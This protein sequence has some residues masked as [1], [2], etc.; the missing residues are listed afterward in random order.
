MSE[1]NLSNRIV[2]AH[3]GS[4]LDQ[5]IRQQIRRLRREVRRLR[6]ECEILKKV[7]A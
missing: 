5:S 7:E 3:D 1:K 2:A 4:S 6:Q